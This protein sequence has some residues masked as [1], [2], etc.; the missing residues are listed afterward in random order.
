M[1]L[2][3]ANRSHVVAVCCV[4]CSVLRRVAVCCSVRQWAVILLVAN[5]SH[6]VAVRCVCCSDLRRVA[7]CCS[8]LQLCGNGSQPLLAVNI[9]HTVEVGYTVLQCVALC[10]TDGDPVGG[11][12]VFLSHRESVLS[13][14]LSPARVR[15][16]SLSPSLS[17]ALFFFSLA[18]S[19][20]GVHACPSTLHA[21]LP[22][23]FSLARARACSLCSLSRSPSLTFWRSLPLFFGPP[24]PSSPLPHTPQP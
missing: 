22:R 16:L 23:S 10:C 5:R 2:L 21:P 20:F 12:K 15:F 13:H 24:P 8:V 7:V 3:V 17:L 18:P 11:E 4:C 19:L 1:I 14:T 6:V 9:C